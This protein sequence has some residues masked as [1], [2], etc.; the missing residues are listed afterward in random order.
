M[1]L[2]GG[3]AQVNVELGTNGANNGVAGTGNLA[4]S[5]AG[6]I[7]TVTNDSAGNGIDG[8]ASLT[9]HNI[10]V[11]PGGVGVHVFNGTATVTSVDVLASS[12]AG[13]IGYKVELS[14]SPAAMGVNI[15]QGS[16]SAAGTT[17]GGLG[18]LANGGLVTVNG[19]HITGTTGWTGISVQQPAAPASAGVMAVA[20]AGN[21]TV[22]G[23]SAAA[24]TLIDVVT[25]LGN[26]TAT[27]GIVVGSGAENAIVN[28]TTP[29]ANTAVPRLTIADNTKVMNYVDGIVVNNGHVVSSGAN[30]I[31]TANLQDGLQ[32]FSSLALTGTDPNDPLARVLI[33]GASFTNNGRAGV[34]I[35]DVVPV[36]LD[37]VK[38][39]G[40]GTNQTTYANKSGGIDVQR[41]Q[42]SGN[43]G[44]LFS[45]SNSTVS[46]NTGCGITLSG[47]EGDF[48]NGVTG[49]RLCGVGVTD[50]L[51]PIV[52]PTAASGIFGGSTSTGGKLSAVLKNDH[53]QNNTGV[54]I[55]VTEAT[56]VDPSTPGFPTVGTADRDVTEV[57][58]QGNL[59]TGN[60]TV[61]PAAGSEP[62]A[63]GIYFAASDITNPN[64][65]GSSALQVSDI[66]CSTGVECTRIR[67]SSFL[68][69]VSSCNGRAQ[70]AF[71]VPQRIS[72]SASGT[73]PD[74]DW[75]ISSDGS[76]VGVDLTMRC[77]AAASPNTLAGYSAT[78]ANLGLAVPLAVDN[79]S[80]QSLL[81]VH[82]YGVKW[83]A[84]TIISGSDYSSA[85]AA[86]SQGNDDASSWGICP[87]G[88]PTTCP[89]ALQ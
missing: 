35:R 68:G 8:S 29:A 66:G 51:G 69:N 65:T 7:L 60:L 76:I 53:V 16:I 72:T 83:N 18:V 63:G 47:G 40:N 25:P 31:S 43:T 75:D 6:N 15:N 48:I 34:L 49:T 44:F 54:G 81:H 58:L 80:G 62:V 19:T 61:V 55:Y 1:N 86:A 50:A 24:S 85:L 11:G 14:N 59:V 52:A 87:G 57:S 4:A 56:D 88:A 36:A 39:T 41:S 73:S 3:T 12:A 84:G 45:L 38:I 22:T 64:A 77:S 30:V 32:V 23:A 28:V 33:T 70:L 78:A 5:D 37:T 67:M 46:G 21:V 10:H 71:G 17:T 79:A 2:S 26:T 42:I 89:V 82:A 9:P 74:G 27:A 20:S 13:F